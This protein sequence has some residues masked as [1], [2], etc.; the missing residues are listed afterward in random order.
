M[1]LTPS[2][3]DAA[4][5]A[6]HRSARILILPHANVDPDAISSALAC[7]SLFRAMGKDVTVACEESLPE[8]LQFLP[9]VATVVRDP[10]AAQ[11]FVV[12]LSLG[13]GVEV[14][15]LRYTVEDR[16]VHIIVVPK[17]GSI[18]ADQVSCADGGMPYDLLVIVDT[19]DLP[20]LGSVYTRSPHLFSTIPVLNI[21]HHISNT[22]FGQ[23]HLID[24]TC[25]ST[26]EVL[27][28]WISRV[29]ELKKLM[30]PDLAT[31]L[32]TGLITDTRSFQNPNTSPRSLEVAASLLD[33]GGR[34][35]EIIQQMYK[36]KPLSTLKI[37]GRALSHIQVD[38]DTRVVWSSVGRED[39]LEMGA[40]SR[41]THG[42]LD[43]LLCTIPGAD[44]YVLFTE[45]EEG[46]LKASLRTS[47][48]VDASA[49]AARAYAGGGHQR[50][51]GFKIQRSGNFQLQVLSAIQR[52][53]QCLRALHAEDAA[54]V[55]SPPTGVPAASSP[56]PIPREIPKRD[57]P[58][59]GTG[60]DVVA[61]VQGC[62]DVSKSQDILQELQGPVL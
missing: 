27:Y 2:A 48:G 32:L 60:M 52:L 54:E 40:G 34:Q 49:L 41:E 44:V 36:T 22:L 28:H 18:R 4:L 16:R 7:A 25:A 23:L 61:K 29:P 42:I 56:P 31:L 15:K 30:T 17:N 9:G 50:A 62:P 14:D 47:A 8:T 39:L 59:K 57:V 37:W 45:I 20:L 24:P 21:D 6:I 38:P 26:T 11:E 35:Q 53:T 3:I 19:A 1:S 43:E 46:G 55:L 10:K 12:T 5:Q 13:E 33:S 51:A 58:A